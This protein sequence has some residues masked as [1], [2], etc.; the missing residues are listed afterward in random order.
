M[1]I[2]TSVAGA[3]AAAMLAASVPARAQGKLYVVTTTEDL[4]SIAREVGGDHITVESIAKGYQDPHFVEAKPSFILKLQKADLL[5]VVGRELEI[6]WL[7]PLVQ[8]S[9]NGKI[10]PGAEGYLDASLTAQIL[11]IPNANIT[12]AMGDVHP[13]G[14]PHY[15][16]DPENGKLIAKA[17]S[18]KLV[19]FRPNDRAV[20][21]Q[22]LAAFASTLDA[23]EKRWLGMMAPYKGTKMAT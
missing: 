6:G 12:R 13:F 5:I 20:F 2:K 23:A 22:R 11:E 14:N 8:Q 1:R 17:I 9:R 4:A 16:T 3:I 7:P 21:E 18:A 19:Q 10:Q 15:W